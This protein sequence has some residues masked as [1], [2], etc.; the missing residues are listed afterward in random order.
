MNHTSLCSVEPYIKLKLVMEKIFISIFIISGLLLF[1][2]VSYVSAAAANCTV[3]C[4]SLIPPATPL[5][6]P[7]NQVCICNP[8][9][10]PDFST[11]VDKLIGFIFTISV[12][13]VPL[14]II[15]GAFLIMTAAGDPKKVGT[16]KNIILYTLIGLAIVLFAKGIIVVIEQLLGVS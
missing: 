9:S 8:L 14:M 15:I 7:A 6:P 5:Q 1:L 13:V 4:N 2:G 10:S 16:G 11:V 12:V 3:Y